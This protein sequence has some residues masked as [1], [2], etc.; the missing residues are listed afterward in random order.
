M[1]H[2]ANTKLYFV[3]FCVCVVGHS[4]SRAATRFDTL[5]FVCRRTVDYIHTLYKTRK[6]NTF[7]CFL[8]FFF[9]KKMHQVSQFWSALVLWADDNAGGSASDGSLRLHDD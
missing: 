6:E 4:L 2:M 1:F 8:F 7:H 5:Q 3:K 9:H